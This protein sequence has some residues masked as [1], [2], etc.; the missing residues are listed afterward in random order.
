MKRMILCLSLALGSVGCSATTVSPSVQTR[1]LW[2]GDAPNFA[3]GDISPDGRYFSD[4]NWESGDLL[5]VDIETGEG[6]DLTGSGYD[7]GRYAWTSSFST[8]GR[9]L[10]VSW[11]LYE[12]DRHE[13]RLMS[14]DGT[15]SRVLVPASRELY[16]VDPLDWSPSD[17]HILVAARGPDL[18]WQLRIV[19]VD[20]GS[21]RVLK[22]LGW[23]APGGD[24]AYPRAYWSPDGEYVA[25]DYRPDLEEPG[26][27]IYALGV[28]GGREVTLVSGSSVNR[29]LG[30]IPDG[31][32]I[33]FHSDRGGTP[34][35][36][37]LPLRDGMIPGEPELLRSDMP[38]L[39]PLGFV[40]GG[41]A[42]G[43][44]TEALQ[45]HVAV[46]D[47]EAGRVLAPPQPVQ[48]PPL[49]SSLSMDWSPDGSRLA[50]F[51]HDSSRGLDELL[52]I[53][54]AD[55][56]KLYEVPLLPMLHTSNGTLNWVSEDEIYLFGSEKGRFGIHRMNPRDGSYSRI[57][58]D[59]WNWGSDLKWFQ[60]A[61]DG[62]TLFV[63]RSPR[64]RGGTSDL[65]A[66]DLSSGQERVVATARGVIR[67]SL[68]VSPDGQEVAYLA[69]DS[70][71]GAVTLWVASTSQFGDARAV[72]R[73]TREYRPTS[74]VTWTPDGSRLLFVL[75]PADGDPSGLWS[76]S[77]NGNEAA[78][79]IMGDGGCCS[80]HDIRVHPGGDRLAFVTGRS[81]GGIWKL[82][83]F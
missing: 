45:V 19:S 27:D 81:R 41:Y 66:L 52:V 51:I 31:S 7:D 33:L 40:E 83:G 63:F 67:Q 53:R 47:P 3:L 60:V 11:Y 64:V 1:L 76:V 32:G 2:S 55:G 46:V 59:E 78:V 12:E 9:E 42:Y 25:Y 56:E 28:D 5:L 72:Y 69:R 48:D 10:A 49:L 18:N 58:P 26:R 62:G 82:E 8:D 14:T 68:A 77:V 61:S 21:V 43:A 30:W 6:R 34:G 39:A 54:S 16:Y 35:V 70:A 36:W 15:P 65:I 13:L 79:L 24:Q 44:V 75:V 80:G 29:L 17:D 74:P 23:L 38:G 37:R 50:Y 22:T 4:V 57:S 71:D 20:D 73:A